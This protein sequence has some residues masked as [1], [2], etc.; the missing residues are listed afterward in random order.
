MGKLV[1]TRMG[2][3]TVLTGNTL[4]LEI[5]MTIMLTLFARH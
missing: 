4:Q 5:L 2:I 1:Y 3:L